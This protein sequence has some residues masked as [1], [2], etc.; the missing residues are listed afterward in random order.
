MLTFLTWAQTSLFMALLFAT[1]CYHVAILVVKSLVIVK[2]R[3]IPIGQSRV[4]VWLHE[5]AVS[6]SLALRERIIVAQVLVG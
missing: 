2:S 5:K 4:V 1:S 3:A 6:K